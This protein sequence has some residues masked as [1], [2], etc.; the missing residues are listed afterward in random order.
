M[1]FYWEEGI[2]RVEGGEGKIHR[3]RERVRRG[4]RERQREREGKRR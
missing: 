4:G 3:Q 2:G 1:E